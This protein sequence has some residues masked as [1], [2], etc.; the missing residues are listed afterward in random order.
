MVNI[1]LYKADLVVVGVGS[2]EASCILFPFWNIYF[3]VL[4]TLMFSTPTDK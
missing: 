3:V 1:L 4:V 2:F